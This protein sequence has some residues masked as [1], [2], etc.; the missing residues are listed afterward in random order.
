MAYAASHS[1]RF[2][3]KGFLD[4]SAVSVSSVSF[5]ILYSISVP[6]LVPVSFR[7]PIFILFFSFPFLSLR[8]FFWQPG[9]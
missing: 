7:I 4:A 3:G 9:T 2:F 5:F 8:L 6:V 1:C